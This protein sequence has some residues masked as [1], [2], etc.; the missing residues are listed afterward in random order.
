MK[1]KRRCFHL[2]MNKTSGRV[3]RALEI[4]RTTR[5]ALAQAKI[6]NYPEKWL[7]GIQNMHS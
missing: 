6:P 7:N 4:P 2:T 1:N 5:V 3:A